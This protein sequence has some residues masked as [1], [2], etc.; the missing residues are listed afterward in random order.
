MFTSHLHAWQVRDWYIES[1]RELRRFKPIK[2]DQDE[3]TFTDLLRD[4]YHRHRH[5]TYALCLCLSEDPGWGC[6]QGLPAPSC[7]ILHP[8]CLSTCRSLAKGRC[9]SVHHCL[10]TV[11][12]LAG[13]VLCLKV[14]LLHQMRVYW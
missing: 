2:D 9:P 13:E 5:A 11:R 1:F 14:C 10:P 12:L 7:F 3:S 6:P 4:I 8:S